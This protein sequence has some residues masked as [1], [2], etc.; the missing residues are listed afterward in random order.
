MMLQAIK[1]FRE[2]LAAG[3]VCLGAGISLSDPLVTDALGDS[4]DF[5]W[6]D[7][8]HGAMSPEIL[9]GHLLAARAR[10]V[11]GIVRVTGSTTPF[12]KP[13][14]DSGAEGIVVPQVRSAEEVRSVVADCRYPPLGR[15][16]ATVMADGRDSRR[17][18]P[19]RALRQR[20]VR[21]SAAACASRCGLRLVALDA[22]TP[23]LP[24]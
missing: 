13:I 2:K 12:I 7:L 16:G 10:R 1:I 6:I 19:V 3:R 11:P 17:D 22:R 8:E 24:G 14:L 20:S 23:R 21:E 9:S 15:R 5:F 18:P 4:V